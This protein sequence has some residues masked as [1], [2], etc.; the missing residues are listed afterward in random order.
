MG[1]LSLICISTDCGIIRYKI[2]IVIVTIIKC[3]LPVHFLTCT[4]V[5]SIFYDGVQGPLWF[6]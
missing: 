4:V 6:L 1:L 5:M 2:L 3:V